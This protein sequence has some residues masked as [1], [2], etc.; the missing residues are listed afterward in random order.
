MQL[1]YTSCERSKHAIPPPSPVTPPAPEGVPQTPHVIGISHAAVLAP[2]L[3]PDDQADRVAARAAR[4]AA[5]QP[6]I[7]A[8]GGTAIAAVVIQPLTSAARAQVV[9]PRA[10]S[11]VTRASSRVT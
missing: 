3:R 10:T 9:T 2:L 4:M 11:F 7:S 1:G 8:L 6:A 5:D